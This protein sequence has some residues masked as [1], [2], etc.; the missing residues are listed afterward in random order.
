MRWTVHGERSIYDSDWVN[1]RLVDVEVPGGPRFEH[2]VVRDAQ[3]AAGTIVFDAERGVLLLWRHRFIT[4][5]WGWEIPAGRVD[6]GETP[7]QAAARETLEETGW[8][9]SSLRP[10]TRYHPTNGTSDQMFHI[11]VADGAQHV[12]EPTDPGESERIE[13]VS[14]TE[15]RRIAQDE[16]ML[17]GLSLT[18]VCYALAFGELDE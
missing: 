17:D 1:L 13:W 2:H 4:D 18:A 9:P 16:Q 14:V 7:R 3:P 15:L 11:F 5:T 6:P 10:L 8:E 12:G